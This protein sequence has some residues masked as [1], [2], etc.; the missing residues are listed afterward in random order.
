MT[1]VNRD[2]IQEAMRQA[3]RSLNEL[4]ETQGWD[5]PPALWSIR[6]DLGADTIL[7]EFEPIVPGEAFVDRVP[8]DVLA[9]LA[10]VCADNPP[11]LE[12]DV[13]GLAFVSEAWTVYHVA[14]EDR[15]APGTIHEHPDRREVRIIAAVD[16]AGFRYLHSIERETEERH[17]VSHRRG[18]V[19]Q[20]ADGYILES[21]DR[22]MQALL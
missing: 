17:E 3:L 2:M 5:Q 9:F 20:E 1:T 15:P 21:L 11:P 6:R 4:Y 10:D 13:F 12:Y 7:F 8:G 18:E 19:D 22:I 16:L 14:E